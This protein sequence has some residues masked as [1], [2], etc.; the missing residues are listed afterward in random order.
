[1][2]PGARGI[3]VIYSDKVAGA[4]VSYHSVLWYSDYHPMCVG[5]P[6]AALPRWDEK[7]DHRYNQPDLL[8][9]RYTRVQ[10]AAVNSSEKG[11]PRDQPS[12]GISRKFM[13]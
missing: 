13:P 5:S 4:T 10:I 6:F 3:A 12:S 8:K 2:S 1:V 11:Y 9:P 7:A